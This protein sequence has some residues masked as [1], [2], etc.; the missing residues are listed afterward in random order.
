MK[1]LA[2]ALL[3]ITTGC[4]VSAVMPLPSARAIWSVAVP[5][6]NG[7]TKVMALSGKA[8]AW[9][10]RGARARAAAASTVGLRLFIVC[11]REVGMVRK[12][13]ES[14]GRRLPSEPSGQRRGHLDRHVEQQEGQRLAVRVEVQRIVDPAVEHAV[15]HEVHR[16]QLR[17]QEALDPARRAMA[18]LGPHPLGR[19]LRHQQ[20]I[21]RGMPG[22]DAD[23]GAVALVA[24]AAVG[25]PVERDRDVVAHWAGSSII[26]KPTGTASR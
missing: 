24:G 16:L 13:E 14:A 15:E 10:G 7:T 20:R 17:Q 21:K 23:V 3:S 22:N 12:Q 26:S 2:P 25:G 19:E 4:F 11:L 8:W 1:P 5:A 18:E 9:P 6:A